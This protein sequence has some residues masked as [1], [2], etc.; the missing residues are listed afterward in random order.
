MDLNA[1][2]TLW[3]F[4]FV[5]MPQAPLK[6]F[7]DELEP[8]RRTKIYV[9]VASQIH[10]LIADGRVKPGE[11]LPP[12]R[13]LAEMF[14][15]S[16]ASVRDAI[17]ILEMH[18][19]VQPRQGEGTVIRRDPVEGVMSPLAD[20]LSLSRDL[21]AD[22]FD[23]RKILEPPLARV[24]ALRATN[25]DIEALEK[26]LDKQAARVRAAEIAID[27]DTAFHYRLA[28]VSKNRVIPRVMDVIMDLLLGS[29][30][31][32]LQGARR[33]EKSLE[34][35]RRIVEAIKQGDAAAAEAAMHRHLSE[36]EKIVLQM[37]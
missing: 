30:A 18:G 8:V 32:S 23:M 11:R 14:D 37:L 17:R 36:I 31:R 2:R 33:S 4:E 34:G 5:K 24:A 15:V 35:H 25:E 27:E 10:R 16:R 26:I 28:T 7:R 13:E 29:R 3:L 22:L 9:E 1:G 6:P 20:A 19:L 12:E 21:T